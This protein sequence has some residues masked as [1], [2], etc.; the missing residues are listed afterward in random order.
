MGKKYSLK[1]K[2]TMSTLAIILIVLAFL[3]VMNVGYSLWSSKLNISGMVTLDFDPPAIE[4]SVIPNVDNRYVNVSG[5][6]N[7][8]GTEL[9]DLVSEEYKK[10]E[11]VTTLRVHKNS[12]SD[13][14]SSDLMVNFSLKNTSE[15]GYVYTDG[16]VSQLEVSNPGEAL[17]NVSA[18]VV[19]ATVS[20]NQSSVFNFSANVNRSEVKGSAYYKYAITY[21]VNGVER[22]FFY[23]IKILE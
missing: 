17:K 21:K 16:K 11:L 10:N 14:I 3:V 7:D 20:A 1:R 18:M 8:S 4:A 6:T 5:L 22:Y 23:T 13:W 15:N 2:H 12:L 9:F 19:P